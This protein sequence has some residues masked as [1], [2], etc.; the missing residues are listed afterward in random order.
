MV[1][2]IRKHLFTQQDKGFTRAPCRGI[3]APHILPFKQRRI[4]Q[5]TDCITAEQ[6]VR[7][8][9]PMC[10]RRQVCRR[11]DRCIKQDFMC[12]EACKLRLMQQNHIFIQAGKDDF[13]LFQ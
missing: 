10:Q 3:D 6:V 1:F 13:A 8:V 12:A 5:R 9:Q 7:V 4:T 11:A 2:D